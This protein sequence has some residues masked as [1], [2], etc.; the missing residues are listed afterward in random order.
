VRQNGRS[1]QLRMRCGV[2]MLNI[3]TGLTMHE[4]KARLFFA[5]FPH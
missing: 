3:F 5:A 2:N 4:P 1:V